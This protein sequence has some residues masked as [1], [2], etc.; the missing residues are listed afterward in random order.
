[1]STTK[2]VLSVIGVAALGVAYYVFAPPSVP[3][4]P[5]PTGP[6]A[7]ARGEYLFNAGGCGACHQPEGTT[8]PVGGYEIKAE[9]PF[10]ITFYTPNITPDKETGIAGWTGKDFLRAVK[11]G[12]KP[13]GGFYWPAFPFRSY[14]G[15]TDA[16]VLDVGAYLMSLPPVS[17]KVKSHEMPPYLF[18]WMLAGWNVMADFMEGTP[19]AVVKMD[20]PKVARGA[21]LARALGH[22]SECHTPRNAFGI[23]MMNKEFEGSDIVHK[24]IDAATMATWGISDFTGFLD[25]GMT[26]SFDFVGGEMA[27]VIKHT[28]LLTPEDKEAYA[29]FFTREGDGKG[30]GD[31]GSF[32]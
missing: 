24:K 22:C 27:E 10:P 1:M 19:P 12:R 9:K 29:A 3:D 4:L 18:S 6:E 28:K 32:D 2:V 11:H 5:L 16:D 7:I 17:N 15:M 8:A 23:M 20:D 14:K 30:S 13:S 21:Y 25:L 26:K 31:G